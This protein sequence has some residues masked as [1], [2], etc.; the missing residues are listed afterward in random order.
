[1]NRIA[2]KGSIPSTFWISILFV[3]TLTVLCPEQALGQTQWATN[4]ND[5]HNTN[6][7]NVGIGT[8]TPVTQLEISAAAPVLTLTHSNGSLD[9]SELTYRSA[10]GFYRWGII[11]YSDS[12]AVSAVSNMLSIFQ[13]TDKNNTTVNQHRFVLADNGNIGIGTHTPGAALEI[14]SAVSGDQLR[15]GSGVGLT[16]SVGRN[17]GDGLLEFSGV[18]ASF[19]GYRFKNYD[20]DVLTI[21]RLDR[22]GNANSTEL[23]FGRGQGTASLAGGT[24]RAPDAAGT[25][26]A[27]ANLTIAS[28]LATGNGAAGDILFNGADAGASGTAAQTATTRMII[29]GGSGNVGIGTTTAARRLTVYDS[30]ANAPTL[31]LKTESS[32]SGLMD[33]FDLQFASSNTYIWNRENGAMMFGTN[34]AERF[35]VTNA[36][37]FG[38]GTATPAYKL[39]VN[40]TINATAIYQNGSPLSTSQWTTNGSN[41]SYNTGNVGIGTTTPGY[42]LDV[43][44]SLNATSI[45]QNGAP[46]LSSQWATNQSNIS[47]SSGNVGIGTNTPQTA[48][49]ANGA[50]TSSFT[51]TAGS[52]LS[53]SGSGGNYYWGIDFRNSNSATYPY[54]LARIAT[55]FTSSGTNLLFGTS[56]N[57]ASGIT[58]TALA[59]R[60][61]GNVGVGTSSPTSKLD[62]NGNLSVTGNINLTGT[63]NA[64]YQDVAEWVPSNEALPAGTVVVLNPTR[65]NQV[66]ASTE[67]YDTRVAGVISDRLG[68]ALGEAGADKV[69]V[70][71][72]GRVRVKVDA[73]RAPV[74]V[75]DLLVTSDRPGVA[76]KSEPVNLGG[77]PFHR[78]GTLI[79][80]ALEPL[81]KGEGEILV[82]LSLQ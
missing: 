42:K 3:L 54:P 30:D 29:K 75:G 79:G 48:L 64:K 2:L 35:R 23:I 14:K 44:G 65:S 37:N 56:N 8:T 45:Y 73:T 46:F 57:Y 16:Y 55:Q 17:T 19:Q 41:I 70:A 66:M 68:L 62:V 31:T 77:V 24:L 59:I 53:I 28:G 63:I 72:T 60:Y 38:I 1:M 6:S 5:I 25:N 82:L 27:G 34:N 40:G 78:P 71:T 39:D 4:G 21:P 9:N 80:K 36:G 7:G 49:Q 15:I 69:L 58:N 74:R 76:M 18:Q 61:D 47:Y 11:N 51:G 50:G 32:G 33:G 10:A 22:T 43:G 52:I 13:F 12:H 67:A 81:A 26:I 20:L